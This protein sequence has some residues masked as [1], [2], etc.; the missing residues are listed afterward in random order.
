MRLNFWVANVANVSGF[1]TASWFFCNLV[2]EGT[3]RAQ[4]SLAS[5]TVELKI[6][7]NKQSALHNRSP[8]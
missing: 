2:Y 6:K 7:M 3:Q 4:D 5:P 8:Y 1:M